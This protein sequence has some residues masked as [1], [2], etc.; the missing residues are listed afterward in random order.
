LER[1]REPVKSGDEF[2]PGFEGLLIGKKKKK[3]DKNPK[4]HGV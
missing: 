1:E 4:A 3:K 2:E